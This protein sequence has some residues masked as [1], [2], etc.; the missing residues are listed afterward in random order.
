MEQNQQDYQSKNN[1]MFKSKTVFVVRFDLKNWYIAPFIT[2]MKNG[3][4]FTWL[5]FTIAYEKLNKKADGTV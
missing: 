3:K 5:C 1:V 2:W 4:Y